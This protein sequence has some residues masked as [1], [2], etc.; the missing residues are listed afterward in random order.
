MR[1][2]DF[3]PEGTD[4]CS[5][6]DESSFIASHVFSQVLELNGHGSIRFQEF[7]ELKVHPFQAIL[8]GQ[9]AENDDDADNLA[10]QF[11]RHTDGH[12]LL[13]RQ[14]G[15]CGPAMPELTRPFMRSAPH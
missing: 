3:G 15:R 7:Q 14:E 5:F 13:A 12:I 11:E 1:L 8:L 6:K 9:Q 10:V 2:A 4:N